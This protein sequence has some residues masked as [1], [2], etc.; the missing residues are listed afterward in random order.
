MKKKQWHKD[1][2]AVR[3]G[4]LRS[5]HQETSEALY[6]NS[7]YVY[8][9]AEEAAAAFDGDLDRYVYSRY[10]NPTVTMLQTRLAAL[11][12]A[13]A[14]LAMGTGMAAM[15]MAVASQLKSGDKIVASR[16]LF[17]ACYAVIDQI[18]PRWGIERVFVDGTDLAAWQAA[19]ADGADMVFLESPSNPMLD[20]VDIKAVAKLAH[21]AGAMVV[22]DNVFATQTGQSPLELGADLVMYSLTKHHDGHGRVLAGALLGSKE[23]LHGDMLKFYRQTGPAISS[24]NAWL[25]LKSLDSMAL[26][27]DRQAENAK[28]I[29]AF[30]VGHPKIDEMRYPHHPS[31]P[32]FALAQEQMRHG[33]TI[34]AFTING[35]QTEAFRFL[36][37]LDLIDISNN[38][39]D[40]KTLACHPATTTHSSVS[41]EDRVEMGIGDGVIRLSVGLEHP[42]DVIAD[43][44]S[45]L[46][47]I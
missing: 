15:F 3:G 42:D 1:T 7:G 16:A 6:L 39:G 17:G 27:I 35:G 33:G 46:A 30:L 43:L 18:L 20:L 36:N 5:S 34:I 14:C 47:A 10:G 44:S 21:D 12:G 28:A 8:D 2:L 13:E 11:E 38:L 29:S 24:F 26:R 4:L 40:S 41:Q 25:I 37:S 32:Q 23:L 31:H 45:A 19:L 9:S 22:V